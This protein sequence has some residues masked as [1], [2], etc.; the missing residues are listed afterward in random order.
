MPA[1]LWL[2]N[3]GGT[4]PESARS[5]G[6]EDFNPPVSTASQAVQSNEAYLQQEAIDDLRKLGTAAD[7]R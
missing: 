4:S 5:A 6:L 7:K 2:A 3:G 1:Q